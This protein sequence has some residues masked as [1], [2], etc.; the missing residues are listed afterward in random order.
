M[1][2]IGASETK[3]RLAIL[4]CDEPHPIVRKEFGSYAQIFETLLDAGAQAMGRPELSPNYPDQEKG[5]LDVS[6]CHVV[7]RVEEYPPLEDVDALLMTGGKYNAFD[8]TPWI[9]KLVEYTKQALDTN[10]IRIV[11]VCFGHQILGR[12]L[13]AKVGRNEGAW[14]VAVNEVQLSEKGKEV[15]GRDVIVGVPDEGA[16][17]EANDCIQSLHQMHRDIVYDYPP[18]AEALG[19]S[20]VCKV[21]GMYSPK[22]L[23]SVQGHPEFKMPILEVIL[24]FRHSQGIFDDTQF[25]NGM[26]KA[27]LHHDG[28]LVAQA[29]LRFMAED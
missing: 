11:G 3:I 15:F 1:G 21:Q 28:V 16:E 18:G 24:N 23:I 14:E 8:D 27:A 6:V 25:E 4:E 26:K 7:D 5:L 19:S 10:R 22:R 20:P 12:A 13:G 9:L 29:F 2:D 17:E